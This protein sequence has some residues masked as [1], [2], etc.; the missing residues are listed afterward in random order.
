[1]PVMAKGQRK[2]PV[3]APTAGQTQDIGLGASV[4]GEG[5]PRMDNPEELPSCLQKK[6]PSLQKV[7]M[8]RVMAP[9]L[10]KANTRK[11]KNKK[12]DRVKKE[13]DKPEDGSDPKDPKDPKGGGGGNGDGGGMAA[14]VAAT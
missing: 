12:P 9:C 2:M 7:M 4:W 3:M 13:E 8:K 6:A 14:A 1:M 10:K 11:E 5:W